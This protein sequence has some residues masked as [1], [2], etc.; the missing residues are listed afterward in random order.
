[1][2][3]FMPAGKSY[4]GLDQIEIYCHGGSEAVKLLLNELL[5]S[6]ARAAE[7]GEFTKL[8][9]LNG[10]IDLT[11]AEA[12]AELI[13]SR[14]C[15]SYEAAREHLAG[16]YAEHLD[17]LRSGLIDI[18]A[19]IETAIDYPEDEITPD[20]GRDITESLNNLVDQVKRLKESYNSGRILREGFKIV[21]GGRPNAGKSTL[22]NLL[23]KQERALVTDT[24]GTT[25]DYLS[26]WIEIEG[27][28][29]NLIDTAG[30]R[31]GGSKIEKAGQEMARE[32]ISKCDLLI[33]IV[34]LSWKNWR[35]AFQADLDTLGNTHMLLLGNKI[36]VTIEPEGIQKKNQAADL[37]QISCL[38]GTGVA[39]LS[40]QLV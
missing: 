7:P 34:D 27:I 21:I 36:D 18:L 33:W 17:V 9:F 39:E 13:D 20:G 37:L 12:V 38:T 1:M 29:V 26:E 4:T 14:T 2:A 28:A 11:Q 10:R 23:L 15:A 24:P 16:A 19:E 30:L 35:S 40:N 3:V 32:L 22:F 8:A 6:G 25:R 31:I 5:N